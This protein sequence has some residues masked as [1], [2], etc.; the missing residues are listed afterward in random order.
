MLCFNFSFSYDN[1]LPHFPGS[2]VLWSL[3]KAP[4]RKLAS[5]LLCATDRVTSRPKLT[6]YPIIEQTRE[7]LKSMWFCF[8][9]INFM[10][11]II[12]SIIKKLKFNLVYIYICTRLNVK[13]CICSLF[14]YVFLWCI[15]NENV[16]IETFLYSWRKTK[17]LLLLLIFKLGD[18]SEHF[19]YIY[20]IYAY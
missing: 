1:S 10:L 14:I 9:K 16:T 8:V 6:F 12:G 11:G 4:Y 17:Q 7:C 13:F 2:Y 15:G 20:Q 18:N 3:L 5:F 19:K